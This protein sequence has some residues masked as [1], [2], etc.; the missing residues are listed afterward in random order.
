MWLLHTRY[1]MLHKMPL[2]LM[3]PI[4]R[5]QLA[6]TDNTVNSNF[7]IT[8]QLNNEVFINVT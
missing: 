3:Q 1:Y 8:E 5:I 2:V 4:F 6:T 7:V